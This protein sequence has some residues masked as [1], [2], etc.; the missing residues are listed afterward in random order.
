MLKLLLDEWKTKCD[1]GML[2]AQCWA[3]SEVNFLKIAELKLSQLMFRKKELRNLREAH[4]A[5]FSKITLS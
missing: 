1:S 2:K 3:S 4:E 5:L